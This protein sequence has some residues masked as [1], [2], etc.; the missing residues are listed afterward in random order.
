MNSQNNPT[1]T[2]TQNLDRKFEETFI[3]ASWRRTGMG[4]VTHPIALKLT[5]SKLMLVRPT[6]EEYSRSGSHGRWYYLRDEVDVLLYLEQSNSGNRSVILSICHLPQEVCSRID[7]VTRTL[8]IGMG[9]S[10]KDVEKAL[11]LLQF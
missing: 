9:A 1:Q 4:A 8:W 7:D 10:T 5:D 6:R 2:P 3:T 11:T